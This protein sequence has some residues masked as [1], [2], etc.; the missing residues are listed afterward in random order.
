MA[1]TDNVP[2]LPQE[3]FD[4]IIDHLFDDVNSL[5]ACALVSASFLSSSRAHLFSHIK[6][7][8]QNP[9][10]SIDALNTLFAQHPALAGRVHS[11]HLC[12]DI[13]RRHSWIE[14][15]PDSAALG[16]AQLAP[17]LGDLSRLVITIDA[18]FVHWANVADALRTSVHAMLSAQTLTRLALTGLYGL[19]LTLF[20]HTP[21]LAHVALKWVTFDERDSPDFATT[22][23]ACVGSPV[24]RLQSLALELDARVL[25]QLVRWLLLPASPVDVST[26]TALACTLDAPLGAPRVQRLLDVCAPVLERLSLNNVLRILDLS[27]HTRLGTL[28]IGTRAPLAPRLHWLAESVLMPAQPLA[29]VLRAVLP[30]IA[31]RPDPALLTAADLTALRLFPPTECITLVLAQV[32]DDFLVREWEMVEREWGRALVDVSHAFVGVVVPGTGA[33]RVLRVPYLMPLISRG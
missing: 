19:P 22:L 15:Y 26:L 33:L 20:A 25:T 14:E 13:M 21:A 8:P 23:A 16:V 7:G 1:E 12:D 17:L 6:I 4:L 24:V 18:G 5:S 11:L 28:C 32:E 9:R 30:D 2:A 29:L 3:L 10:T 31:L 27:A